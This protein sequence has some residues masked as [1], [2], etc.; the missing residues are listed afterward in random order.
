MA[1]GSPLPAYACTHAGP[2]VPAPKI[3]KLLAAHLAF[4]AKIC[5][6]PALDRE[7]KTVDFLTFQDLHS[8]P[9]KVTARFMG[10]D[11]PD[12]AVSKPFRDRL[13]LS[14]TLLLF[15]AAAARF[16]FPCSG[17]R[18]R[19]G[20]IA[21]RAAATP[22]L[23]PKILR[24]PV[25]RRSPFKAGR[26]RAAVL[27]NNHL[28]YLD[29]IVLGSIQPQVFVSKSEVAAWPVIGR[30]TR[31]AG[32]LYIRRREKGDVIQLA[33]EMAKVIAA[34]EVLTL[35]LE[36][37]QQRAVSEVLPFRPSLLAPAVEH[38]W[39]ATAA[40]DSLHLVSGRRLGGG[41]GLLLARHDVSARICSTCFPKNASGC[42]WAMERQ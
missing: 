37:N 16:C 41:R 12:R 2:P 17:L 26:R 21:A 20:S 27:V 19:G 28:S 34:G 39:P 15:L 29:I 9:A 30:L 25:L 14:F 22:L 11:S 42:L 10:W 3:P 35:F 8:M 36:G 1:H 18:G 32:T 31:C 7:F 33:D 4:G 40:R 13:A 38:H 5:G 23:G 6:P 24:L